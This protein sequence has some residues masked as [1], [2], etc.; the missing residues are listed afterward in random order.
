MILL[1]HLIS[2]M[3]SNFFITFFYFTFVILIFFKS[4]EDS[5]CDLRSFIFLL[6]ENVLTFSNSRYAETALALFL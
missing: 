6:V 5:N 4:D 1:F 2:G 3:R